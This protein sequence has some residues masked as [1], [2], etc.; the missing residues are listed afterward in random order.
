MKSEPGIILSCVVN[1]V[2]ITTVMCQAVVIETLLL[3]E[4]NVCHVGDLWRLCDHLSPRKHRWYWSLRCSCETRRAVVYMWWP[5]GNEIATECELQKYWSVQKVIASM[6]IVD[7]I[8]WN[9]VILHCKMY[10]LTSLVEV[11]IVSL[12]STWLVQLKPMHM[13]FI[14]QCSSSYGR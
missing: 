14:L 2:G 5:Q 12:I 13:K 1:Y 11:K 10:C 6:T 7:V 4:L 3:L 8:N 9:C